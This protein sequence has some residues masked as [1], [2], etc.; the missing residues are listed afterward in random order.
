MNMI[1][2]LKMKI[3]YIIYMNNIHS[4]TFYKNFYLDQ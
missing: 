3:I 1:N 2:L 4:R